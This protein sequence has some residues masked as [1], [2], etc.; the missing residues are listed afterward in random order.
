MYQ[1]RCVIPSKNIAFVVLLNCTNYK[2]I[3][4]V[5][6]NTEIESSDDEPLIDLAGK[7]RSREHSVEQELKKPKLVTSEEENRYNLF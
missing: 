6:G 3:S 2:V 5:V 1:K 7:G 4:F